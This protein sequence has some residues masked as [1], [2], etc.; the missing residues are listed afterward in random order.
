LTLVLCL[1][2]IHCLVLPILK[3]L[4][5]T[6]DFSGKVKSHFFTLKNSKTGKTI[7]TKEKTPESENFVFARKNRYTLPE[8]STALILDISY[9]IYASDTFEKSKLL[10]HY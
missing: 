6:A 10:N 8:I 9:I 5:L 7:R 1:V 2:L 3:A 4:D